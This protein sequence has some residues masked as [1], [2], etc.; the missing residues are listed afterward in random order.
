[1]WENMG[2]ASRE[3]EKNRVKPSRAGFGRVQVFLT[4][5]K[6]TS[7]GT[8]TICREGA[9]DGKLPEMH[10]MALIFRE[11]S[12][13]GCPVLCECVRQPWVPFQWP[14]KAAL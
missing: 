5:D 3:T 8:F 1:M 11:P 10:R 12:E 14:L 6:Q 4:D 13:E 2:K 7:G 9:A